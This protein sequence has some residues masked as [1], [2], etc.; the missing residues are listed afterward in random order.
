MPILDLLRRSHKKSLSRCL[1]CREPVAEGEG[2][3]VKGLGVFCSE[4]HAVK[5]QAFSMP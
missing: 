1:E 3:R 5:W 4:D 2:F